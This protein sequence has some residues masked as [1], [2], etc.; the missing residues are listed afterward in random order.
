M[1]MFLGDTPPEGH[2]FFCRLRV[3]KIFPLSVSLTL[4]VKNVATSG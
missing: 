1:E 2:M 3:G 4:C